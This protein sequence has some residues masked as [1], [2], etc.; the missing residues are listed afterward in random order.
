LYGV[1][2]TFRKV[3]L[4]QGERPSQALDRCLR[5][6]IGQPTKSVFPIPTVW[7]TSNSAGYY[8]AGLLWNEGAPTSASIPGLTWL[9][10]EDAEAKVNRSKNVASRNR[11]FGLPSVDV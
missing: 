1:S 4:L 7:T 2:A 9:S 10:L 5:D 8:F 3:R 6:Q 11:D